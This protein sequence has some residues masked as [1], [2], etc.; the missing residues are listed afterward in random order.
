MMGSEQGKDNGKPLHLVHFAKPFQLGRY[1]VT[2][3]EYQV[4]AY[5]IN[6][7]GGCPNPD[8]NGQ[9]N[10]QGVEPNDNGWGEA[11]RPAINV[12]W[13]EAQCYVE[14]LNR[15]H[16]PKKPYRLPTET[17]WEYAARGGSD[18][19][20]FWGSDENLANQHAWFYENSG[21]RTQPVGAAGHDNRFGL[22][23]MAGN[24]WEW[25]ED[26]WHENY[27]NAPDDGKPWEGQDGGICTERVL[28]G[29]AWLH[30]TIYLRSAYRARYSAGDR[31]FNIGFRLAQD[32]P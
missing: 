1:E 21:G 11:H 19:E 17:E 14:W 31:E 8:S 2:F 7:D 30:A 20:Y 4:F 27:K 6:E 15:V 10:L 16:K 5:L 24:V 18:S 22:Y 13:Y 32:L 28:R 26:C 23:D 12:S 3:T 29:G 25:M 9:M